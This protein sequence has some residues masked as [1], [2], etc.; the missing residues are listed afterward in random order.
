MVN[1]LKEAGKKK[2]SFYKV[3]LSPLKNPTLYDKR[4]TYKFHVMEKQI[5]CPGWD[6]HYVNGVIT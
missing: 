2:D 4:F 5:L 1:H 6:I 3:P